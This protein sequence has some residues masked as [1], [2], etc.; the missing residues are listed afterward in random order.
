MQ[1][2]DHSHPN[3]NP[4]RHKHKHTT[5]APDVEPDDG[6][7]YPMMSETPVTMTVWQTFTA[8]FIVSMNDSEFVSELAKR[9]NVTLKFVEATSADASTSYNLMLSSGDYTDIVRPGEIEYPGGPDK[10][11]E[12]GVFVR[13]NEL[14]ERLAPNYSAAR[15]SNVEA[16]RQSITDAGNMWS[17]YTL[18]IPAEYPWNGMAIRK[19]LLDEAG[20]PLPVTLADWEVSLQSFLDQGI[21]HPLLL[22]MTGTWLNGEF[23]SA[24][25][26]GKEFYQKDGK[27]HYGYI[28]PEFKEYLTMMNDWYNKKLIDQE[29]STRGI[30]FSIFPTFP[31]PDAY[32]FI[33][34]GKAAAFNIPWGFT[35]VALVQNGSTQIEGF[36]LA[37][38]SNPKM[39]AGDTVHFRYT[40]YEAKTPNAIT[41]ACKDPELAVKF[42]D[43]LYTEEGSILMNY[44]IE[45]SSYTMVDGKP[46][47]TDTV[48]KNKDGFEPRSVAMKY[49]W[50]DGIGMNDFKRLWQRY[51]GTDGEGALKAYDVWNEDTNLNMLPKITR[52]A[53]EGEQYSSIYNDIKTY[54]H[55]NIPNFITGV[56]PLSDF[57]AFVTQIKS[58]KIDTCIDIQQAALDRYMGR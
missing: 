53:E 51:I 54:A 41:S 44:G 46:F 33:L 31:S 22:D 55:E 1:K 7:V 18:A 36:F 15:L 52:T 58:M 56:K 29:F 9:T 43:Y 23:L 12:D 37:P 32:A 35:D 11:V 49:A 25:N 14:V 45:G 47:Y 39:N 50:D 5:K 28:E 30:T 19:D 48:L 17:M 4:T 2:S 26:V 6:L 42:L 24:W 38:V 3:R 40:S 10:A 20:L 27:V 57:D 21:D 16:A 13:L 34:N 8:D